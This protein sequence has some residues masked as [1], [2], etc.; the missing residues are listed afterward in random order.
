MTKPA[1][2]VTANSREAI[3]TVAFADPPTLR[4]QIHLEVIVGEPLEVGTV[5]GGLRRVVPILGGT[6]TGPLMSGSVIAGG[7]DV[8]LIRSGT[9]TILDAT[10]LI[11]TDQHET[12]LVTNSGV[13]TGSAKDIDRLRRDEPVEP[14]KIYFRSTPRFE[15]SSR[16]LRILNRRIF[17]ATGSRRPDRVVLDVFEVM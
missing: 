10:Y 8:Q 16:R 5:S 9:E 7:N 13:R 11:E 3:S 17:V 1:V 12:I 4:H 6:V 2:P 14:H 15:T